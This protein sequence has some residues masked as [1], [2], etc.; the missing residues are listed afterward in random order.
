MS[1]QDFV[2]LPHYRDRR[3][4]IWVMEPF[5]FQ[6]VDSLPE[7]ARQHCGGCQV[8]RSSSRNRRSS[9]GE[10]LRRLHQQQQERLF[11]EPKVTKAL[12]TLQ[13]VSCREYVRVCEATWHFAVLLLLTQYSSLLSQNLEKVISLIR[14]RETFA[15]NVSLNPIKCNALR[16]L[17]CGWSVKIK[18]IIGLIWD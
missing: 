1:L 17:T 9:G 8:H 16:K 10:R 7:T 14:L 3:S 6:E 13:N 4:V 18:S 12:S 15:V 5:F 11:R 2:A